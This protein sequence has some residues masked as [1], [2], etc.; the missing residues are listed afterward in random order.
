MS[1]ITVK[2][3]V[4]TFEKAQ[5]YSKFGVA[6]LTVITVSGA[7]LVPVEWNEYLQLAIAI[8]G[9][10]AVYGIEN[11]VVVTPAEVAN[12]YKSILKFGN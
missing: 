3:T 9:A 11:K 6:M 5:K 1:N 8:M 12:E 4:T 10:F 2:S 7:G